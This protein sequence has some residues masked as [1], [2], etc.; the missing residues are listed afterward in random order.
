MRTFMLAAGI[1][2]FTAIG[3]QAAGLEK[4]NG[5]FY[6][7]AEGGYGKV[8]NSTGGYAGEIVYDGAPWLNTGSDDDNGGSIGVK[9]GMHLGERFRMDLGY[10]YYGENDFT[11][12][13][14]PLEGGYLWQSEA[15][16]HTVMLAAYYDYAQFKKVN[17]YI[18]AGIGASF[19]D[20][21]AL[22]YWTG[23]GE[24]SGWYSSES[25]TLFSWQ[26]E[27]GIEYLLAQN[28]TLYGGFR[29]IDLGEIDSVVVNV[30]GPDG[31]LTADL[32]VQEIFVG[33]RYRF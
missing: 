5:R 11:T 2:A 23:S 3:S 13:S 25:D 26:V 28:I 31:N 9:V 24:P 29:Y 17:L 10:A 32:D 15:E 4:S 19:V 21:D 20:F 6:V 12:K 8:E 14:D 33:L 16:I 27:T 30:R 18:G 22:E 1:V 7:A